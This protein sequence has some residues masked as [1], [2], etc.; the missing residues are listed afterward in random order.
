MIITVLIAVSAVP[1]FA[2]DYPGCVPPNLPDTDLYAYNSGYVGVYGHVYDVMINGS[3]DLTAIGAAA[4]VDSDCDCPVG[5]VR[6]M[7]LNDGDVRATLEMGNTAVRKA[8]SVSVTAIGAVA[9]STR[10]RRK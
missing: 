3:L 9:S 5:K 7:A 10:S 8:G 2:C 6:A 1:V 4:L